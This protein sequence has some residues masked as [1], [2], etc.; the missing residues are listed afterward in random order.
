MHRNSL[1]TSFAAIACL[2]A[3]LACKPAAAHGTG[4]PGPALPPPSPAALAQLARAQAATAR[5]LDVEQAEHEGYVDI[6]L[7]IPNMGWHYL[8]QSLVDDKFELESP[9]LLVYA[10]DPCGGKRQLVAVEYAVPLAESRNAPQGYAG[11]ADGWEVNADFGLWTLHA[12][13]WNYNPTGV[14]APLNPRVA[15]L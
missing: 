6:G 7:F 2:T 10:D 1:A 15:T 13:I 9:E 5:F 11:H 14:F 12:W 8:K 3:T 4:S